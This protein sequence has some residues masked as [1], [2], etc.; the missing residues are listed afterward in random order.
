MKSIRQY[1][2]EWIETIKVSNDQKF[3]D[4]IEVYKK[5]NSLLISKLNV[6][7]NN[8]D[9]A[10]QNLK[11]A[12][13][14]LQ[15]LKAEFSVNPKQEFKI[16]RKQYF[17]K[18][19]KNIYL[20]ESLN[21]I[22]R[23]EEYLAKYITFLNELKV[24][25]NNNVDR[26]V[27]DVVS[28]VQKWING[29]NDDY[30][31]DK[32]SF[33]TTEYWLSPQEAFDYYV[34]QENEGDCEDVSALLYGCIVAKLVD[35]NVWEENKKRLKRID[36]KIVGSGGHALLTWEKSNN[37]WVPIEST[38]GESRFNKLWV[39]NRNIFKSVYVDVWHIFDE[40]HEYRLK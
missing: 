3:K 36:I 22:S 40:E 39:K 12:N 4:E 28:K 31:T 21:N 18:P 34:I 29:D 2:N 30:D 17:W 16:V 9:S 11:I 1:W 33:G 14:N 19:K 23:D 20:H 38:F 25:T 10:L 32:E 13:D 24:K 5:E 35:N 26:Q 6:S 37:E 15:K 27:Y 7:Q 8:L